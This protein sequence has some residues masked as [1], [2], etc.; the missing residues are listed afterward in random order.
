MSG[1]KLSSLALVTWAALADCGGSNGSAS[2]PPPTPT[3]V[4]ARP[5]DGRVTISWTASTGATSYN[6]Y[7]ST[8]SGLT[9]SS[10]TKLSNVVSPY[11]HQGLTN[12]T[13]YYYVVTAQNAL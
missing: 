11:V 12:E 13:P 1:L 3:G 7:W 5:G 10:G 6:L 2:A 8:M 9:K 4:Q